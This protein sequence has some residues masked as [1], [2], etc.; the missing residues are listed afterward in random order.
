MPDSLRRQLLSLAD[1]Y[2]TTEFLRSDPSQFMHRYSDSVSQERSAFVASALSYGNRAQFMPKIDALL[3]VYL[4]DKTFLPNTDDCYYRLHT[5][6]MVNRFLH[7]L[8]TIYTDYGSMKALLQAH[9]VHTGIDAIKFITYYFRRRE[10]SDLVP[11]NTTST[12]KRLCLFLRW[13]VRDG[14]PVDL[15]LWSDTIDKSTLIIPLD[16]HVMQQAQKLGLIS[17]HSATMAM[18]L[19]LT[20]RLKEYFPNDPLRADFALFGL[21]IDDPSR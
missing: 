16:T 13:M 11:K 8:N 1:H 10:V 5:N 3:Q 12:C 19:R 17:T 14:S 6:K 4:H 7:T 2:E 20:H 9:N 15:G 18:A 21:G